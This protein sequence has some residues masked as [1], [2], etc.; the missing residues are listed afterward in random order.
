MQHGMSRDLPII[1]GAMYGSLMRVTSILPKPI[2]MYELCDR[3]LF[4]LIE[5]R[6]VVGDSRG[7]N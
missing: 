1:K 7:L 5:G 4:Q 3:T 6:R 2:Y